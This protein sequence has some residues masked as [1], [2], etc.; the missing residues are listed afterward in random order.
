MSSITTSAVRGVVA[1]GFGKEG[2]NSS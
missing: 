1:L 2:K